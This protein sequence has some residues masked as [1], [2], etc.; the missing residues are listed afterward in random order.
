[1]RNG[2]KPADCATTNS[3]SADNL[4]V[5]KTA[6]TKAAIGKTMAIIEGRVRI[7]SSTNTNALSPVGNQ[8]IEQ[9]NRPVDPIDQYQN[10]G[11]KAKSQQKLPKH[12]SV[13]SGQ[14]PPGNAISS[15]P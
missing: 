6:A 9:E 5:T 7:E 12:I 3:F 15:A 8:L 1:M 4:L 10:K 2:P 14:S 11:K 13:K